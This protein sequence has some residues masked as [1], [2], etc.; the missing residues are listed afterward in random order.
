[1]EQV[2]NVGQQV[3]SVE[4]CSFKSL[5]SYVPDVSRPYIAFTG[6]LAV[7]KDNFYERANIYEDVFERPAFLGQGNMTWVQVSKASNTTLA[8]ATDT[9][10][11]FDTVD[12]VLTWFGDFL[13]SG[14]VI[15]E[16]G[17]YAFSAHQTFTS[18]AAGHKRL[19]VQINGVT[20]ASGSA[21]SCDDSVTASGIQQLKQ[22]DVIGASIRQETG[23]SLTLAGSAVATSYLMAKRIA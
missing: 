16:N 14:V 3:L 1:M 8:N 15:P 13:G 18:P 10:I 19:K 7:N 6:P 20:V 22:G 5:G 17:T 2:A 4:G 21:E 23:A 11:P 9:A 12:G